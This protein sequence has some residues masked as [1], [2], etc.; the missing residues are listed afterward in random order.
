MSSTRSLLQQK[1][2]IDIDSEAAVIIRFREKSAS[3]VA[4][5]EN[6]PISVPFPIFASSLW[7]PDKVV[8]RST[9]H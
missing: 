7:I 5:T 4:V 6:S 3:V 9:D 8:K 1:P 2:T